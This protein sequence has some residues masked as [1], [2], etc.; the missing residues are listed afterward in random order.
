MCYLPGW[1]LIGPLRVVVNLLE[2]EM[3][4]ARLNTEVMEYETK[5]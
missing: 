4:G 2:Y 5:S 3:P 1:M